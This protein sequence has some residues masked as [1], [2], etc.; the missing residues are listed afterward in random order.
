MP[1]T[2]YDPAIN[3]VPAWIRGFSRFAALSDRPPE[4]SIP[5]SLGVSK[6]E[7]VKL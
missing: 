1:G 5:A 4:G 6:Q 7:E 2:G 3:V